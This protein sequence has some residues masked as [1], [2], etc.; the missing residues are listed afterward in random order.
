MNIND[1][2]VQLMRKNDQISEQ[3][4]HRNEE[5]EINHALAIIARD[6]R[7]REIAEKLQEGEIDALGE[8]SNEVEI[9]SQVENDRLHSEELK[10]IEKEAKDRKS[11]LERLRAT[12]SAIEEANRLKK[13]EEEEIAQLERALAAEEDRQNNR[14]RKKK[15]SREDDEDEEEEWEGNFNVEEATSEEEEGEDRPVRWSSKMKSSEIKRSS[16]GSPKRRPVALEDSTYDN[17]KDL[18]KSSSKTTHRKPSGSPNRRPVALGDFTDDDEKDLRKSSLKTAR[19]KL[20][21][22]S[23]R[24]ENLQSMKSSKIRMSRRNASSASLHVQE[25]E[26]EDSNEEDY[27]VPPPP[28]KSPK[29]KRKPHTSPGNLPYDVNDL[30]G[31]FQGFTPMGLANPHWSGSGSPMHIPGI[32][33]NPYIPT[34]GASFSPPIIPY[35]HGI[36]IPGS[37]VNSGVGNIISST[38]ANVGNNNSVNKVYRK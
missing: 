17:E 26:D 21:T 16:S 22:A 7:D 34:H 30:M 20:S 8:I 38:I 3:I 1:V 2:L 23:L 33:S 14:A 18:R 29:V 12:A 19:R 10:K 4:L 25:T 24:E 31:Q 5:E 9:D 35:G 6:A 37:I 36:G 15:S 11:Q 13:A 28:R 27:Y 32:H